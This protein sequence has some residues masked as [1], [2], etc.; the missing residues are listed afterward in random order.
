[1]FKKKLGWPAAM[2]IGTALVMGQGCPAPGPGP[3]PDPDVPGGLQAGQEREFAGMD[4]IY[5]PAGTF[6]MGSNAELAQ[7]DETPHQVTLTKGF[8]ISKYEVTQAEWEAVMGENPSHMRNQGPNRPVDSVSW[9]DVQDFLAAL[10]EDNGEHFRLPNEAEWE[11]ACR[12]GST[13]EYAFGND[14]GDFSS[15]YPGF[16]R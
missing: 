4:F 12:A 14:P 13:T 3:D 2:V 1:M 10:N 6:N 15:D 11:Y 9:N 5:C 8:W 7:A 16:P